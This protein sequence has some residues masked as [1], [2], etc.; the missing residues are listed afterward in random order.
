MLPSNTRFLRKDIDALLRVLTKRGWNPLFI[1]TRDGRESRKEKPLTDREREILILIGDGLTGNEIAARL[2][3]S[4]K[5]VVCHKTSIRQ[6]LNLQS[7]AGP[8]QTT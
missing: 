5:T 3:L 2:S 7:I 6:K 4:L 1:T 8:A